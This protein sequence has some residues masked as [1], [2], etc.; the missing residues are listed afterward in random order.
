MLDVT[1]HLLRRYHRART[2]VNM[3]TG[4]LAEANYFPRTCREVY[5][6]HWREQIE[7]LLKRPDDHAVALLGMVAC[8]EL[9]FLCKMGL[10]LNPKKHSQYPRPKH[11][12]EEFFP[13]RIYPDAPS[14]RA[15]ARPY[16]FRPK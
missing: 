10:P 12:I 13:K 7:N 5:E 9:A 6:L 15:K 4:R 2:I 3:T 8:M 11:I 14:G 1:I 16:N